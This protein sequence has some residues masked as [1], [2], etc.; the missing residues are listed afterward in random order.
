MWPW[1]IEKEVIQSAGSHSTDTGDL[2]QIVD[3]RA[4]A[5][6]PAQ[7]ADIHQ[8]GSGVREGVGVPEVAHLKWSCSCA[9][10]C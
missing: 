9:R 6:S 7:G 3:T 2:V 1:A 10:E 8:A 5:E 4:L